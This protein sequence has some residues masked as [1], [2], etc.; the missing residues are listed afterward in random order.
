L[1]QAKYCYVAYDRLLYD[2]I[3]AKWR[4]ILLIILNLLYLSYILG[5]AVE[6]LG[7]Q[8]DVLFASFCMRGLTLGIPYRA[9][10]PIAK[11]NAG[12]GWYN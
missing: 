9:Q 4:N 10:V 12:P 11:L 5:D 1:L 2:I 8:R 3:T 6:I 7:K